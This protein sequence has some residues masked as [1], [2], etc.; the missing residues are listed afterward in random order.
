MRYSF[1][2]TLFLLSSVVLSSVACRQ[3][4]ATHKT[5]DPDADAECVESFDPTRDYFPEKASFRHAAAFSVEYF[6]H[7]KVL[8]LERPWPGAERPIRYLLLLCGTPR[9]AGYDDAEVIE[10]P[11]PTLL[12]TSTTELPHVVALGLVDRLLGHDEL[13]YVSSPEIRRRIDAGELIEIGSGPALNFEL[14]VEA[15]PGLLLADSLGEPEL[16]HLEKL[17]QAGVPVALAPAFLETSPLGRA[18][19]IKHTALF[20][21]RE[22]RA[23]EAFA[24]VEERYTALAAE[25]RRAL[26]GGVRPPVVITGGPIGDTWWVPGGR[27]NLAQLLADAGA[28][29]PWAEDPT[30]GS[31]PLDLESVYERALDADFWLHPGAFRSRQEIR[32]LDRRL[33]DFAAF[34]SGRVFNYDARVNGLGGYDYFETG[35]ARP[36][37][38]LADFVKIFHP[39][40]MADHQLVFHRRLP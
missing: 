32:D 13:D 18:E 20:F 11:A 22:G 19:W 33:A 29:Y 6:P 38:V 10:I 2:A 27:S 24:E 23:E 1:R 39:E 40:L 15:D 4:D 31:L 9:P 21:N 35:T 28:R 3:P 25:V 37:L 36:D 8:N 16:A 17:R 14:V 12:T 30:A 5:T 7:Y 26:D 34:K